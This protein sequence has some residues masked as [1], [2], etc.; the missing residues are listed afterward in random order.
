M[1][2]EQIRPPAHSNFPSVR[3]NN[4]GLALFGL[5]GKFRRDTA[6][7]LKAFQGIVDMQPAEPALRFERLTGF[8]LAAHGSVAVAGSPLLLTESAGVEC[9]QPR[10]GTCGRPCRITQVG[11]L[12][13]M[14]MV[15]REFV[16]EGLA[17]QW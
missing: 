9:R 14:L 16:L 10:Y 11:L 3:A 7:R 6:T 8:W 17:L 13:G 4:I 2:F 1:R 5:P 15:L 12:R